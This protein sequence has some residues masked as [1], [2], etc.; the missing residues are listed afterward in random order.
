[1]EV[2][3][4]RILQAIIT[5]IT[6][7]CTGCTGMC[8][9]HTTGQTYYV[10]YGCTKNIV[11]PDLN[12]VYNMKIGLVQTIKDIGFFDAY[13]IPIIGDGI[14]LDIIEDLIQHNVIR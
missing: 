3:K 1:M 4:K 12:A 11:K 10:K 2:I 14:E 13:E 5:G 6:T 9:Y 8:T 7:I